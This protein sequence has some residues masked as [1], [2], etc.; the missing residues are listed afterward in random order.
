MK[1]DATAADDSVA[2]APQDGHSIGPGGV[3]N[4]SRFAIGSK[5]IA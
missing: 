1:G 2:R 5:V 3:C 4:E